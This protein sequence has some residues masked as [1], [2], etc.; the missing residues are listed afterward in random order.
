MKKLLAIF[1]AA[2]MMLTIVPFSA[3]AKVESDDKIINELTNGTFHHVSYV[4]EN[5]YFKTKLGF[6]TAFHLYDDAWNNLIT[7]D[8]DVDNARTVL[9]GLIE[10]VEAEFNNGTY[11][12]ILAALGTAKSAADLVGKLDQYTGLL[13]LAENATWAKSLTG[14]GTVLKVLNYSNEIYEEFIKGY[15]L[16]LSCQAASI[17]Y[18]EFLDYIANNCKSNK[19]VQKAAA[20]LKETI[21][22][23]LEEARDKL[24]AQLAGEAGK[25]GAEVVLDLVLSAFTVTAIIKTVFNVVGSVSDKLFKTKDQYTYMS[26]L[27]IITQIEE[28]LPGFVTGA[29]KGNNELSANFA[30]NALVTLHETGE[31]M[32]SNLSKVKEDSIAGKLFSDSD[33]LSEMIRECALEKVKLDVYRMVLNSEDTHRTYDVFVSTD[34]SKKAVV[35]DANGDALITLPANAEKKV[36]DETGAYVSVY[37]ENLGTY[38]KVM[39]TFSDGCEVAYKKPTTSGGSSSSSSSSGG[40]F[41]AMFANFF[42]AFA[43]LFK[44]LFS[45]GK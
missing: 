32:L 45:F 29:L 38:V 23:S 6:Y 17:Y 40:G 33:K 25:D 44:A 18:G 22:Q 14:V 24:I 13:G 10:Q 36:L 11:E 9:V 7:G 27:A 39:V 16:I 8:V 2:V 30:V 21:T 37:N 41:A 15:A 43:N 34:S 31:E 28:T 4:K 35:Y 26:S 5:N 20:E 3:F 42:A 12:K 19:N 1:L